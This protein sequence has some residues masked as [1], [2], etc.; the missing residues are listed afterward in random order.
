[1]ARWTSGGELPGTAP[2][3]QFHACMQLA[4]DT[5]AAG[6]H[7]TLIVRR[8]LAV[9]ANRDVEQQSQHVVAD[10]RLLAAYARCAAVTHGT[11]SAGILKRSE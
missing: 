5:A 8:L 7:P 2:G 9:V 4:S 11:A 10:S 3:L 1:M 6:Q